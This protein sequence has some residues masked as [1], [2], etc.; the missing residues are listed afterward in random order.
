MWVTVTQ[1]GI[2]PAAARSSRDAGEPWTRS[3]SPT[4]AYEVGITTGP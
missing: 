4:R 3:S 1:T 2:P